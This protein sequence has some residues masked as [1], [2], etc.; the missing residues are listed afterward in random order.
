MAF[1]IPETYADAPP[2]PNDGSAVSIDTVPARLV[3]AK[4]F[5][6][7]A[8]EEE[9]QRQKEALLE[10]LKAEGSLRVIDESAVSVLQYNSPLTVPWRRRNE[11]A[12]VVSVSEGE[13]AADSEAGG[14]GAEAVVVSWYDAGMRLQ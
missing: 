14:E 13:A 9:V 5:A 4:P 6:G 7:L 3:A 10:A 1:V 11:V 8:T 2:S 12:F